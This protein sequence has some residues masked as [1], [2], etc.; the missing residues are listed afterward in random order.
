MG[1]WGNAASTGEVS[2]VLNKVS[3]Y[4]ES[5]ECNYTGKNFI[6]ADVWQTIL[7]GSFYPYHSFRLIWGTP[8]ERVSEVKE[9][10]CYPNGVAEDWYFCYLSNNTGR[11]KVLLSGK[12]PDG[13]WE[14]DEEDRYHQ[15]QNVL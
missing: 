6:L 5:S 12:L 2:H 9:F 8:P 10:S 11:V 3:E 13:W 15:L 7:N 14:L 4:L 1:A